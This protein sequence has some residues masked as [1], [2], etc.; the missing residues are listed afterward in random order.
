LNQSAVVPATNP[1]KRSLMPSTALRRAL[2]A[3]GHAMGSIVQVGK[4][5]VT[6]GLEVHLVK[7]LFDHEL[8]KVRLAVEC[9]LDRFA[10]AERLGGVPGVKIV[11][12]LGRTILL[13]K[14]HPQEPRFEGRRAVPTGATVT[15]G[16]TGAT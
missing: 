5:G 1:K 13:Y 6:P 15:T 10:V 11:Q 7:A 12:I 9:P 14:R 8:V 4:E 3:H 16:A 2:R